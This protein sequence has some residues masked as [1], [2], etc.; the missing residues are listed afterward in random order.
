MLRKQLEMKLIFQLGTGGLM[1]LTL[2]SNAF[3]LCVRY[4][5]GARASIQV[6]YE[7]CAF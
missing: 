7:Y 5:L 4:F 3:E 1:A 2:I 6:I